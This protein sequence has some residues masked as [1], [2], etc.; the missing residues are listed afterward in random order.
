[1]L[2]QVFPVTGH[3]VASLLVGDDGLYF[4]SQEFDSAAAFQ[5]A[6]DKKLSLATKVKISYE[7]M[8][9]VRQEDGER[10]VAIAYR[11]LGGFPASYP[12]T[13][14]QSADE[15]IFFA[16]LQQQRHFARQYEKLS[17][18]R[19][20]ASYAVGA[21]LVAVLT[22]FSY[23][24]ALKIAAGTVTPARSGKEELFN[25]LVGALGD[26]GVLA[27]GGLGLAYLLYKV[28]TRF[29]NPPF[30]QCFVPQVA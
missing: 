16:Y 26:K 11:G 17:P 4:S 21:V 8:K 10:D 29:T 22:W 15:E 23:L 24:E 27:V 25:D 30:H 28:W 5:A 3:K 14:R 19:A 20:T 7:A 13:F 18:L 6:W 12:F 2:D 1:M 9:A